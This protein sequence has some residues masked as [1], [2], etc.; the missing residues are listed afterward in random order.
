MIVNNY[1]EVKPIYNVIGY[2]KGSEEPGMVN[3]SN[4]SSVVS[5]VNGESV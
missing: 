1:M 4:Y 3:L 2:I 5:W